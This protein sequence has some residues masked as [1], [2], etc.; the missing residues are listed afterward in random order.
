MARHTRKDKIYKLIKKLRDVPDI[1]IRTSLIVGFPGETDEDFE[2]LLDFVQILQEMTFLKK[3]S[4]RC[5][6]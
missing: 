6:K 4:K 5:P 1:T 3:I 2:N